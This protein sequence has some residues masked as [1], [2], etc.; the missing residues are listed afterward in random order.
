MKK[1]LVLL[2]AITSIAINQ[3]IAQSENN[4]L[5]APT[6][7]EEYNYLTK[8]YK[9]QVESG[10]D[11]KKGYSLIDMGTYQLSF[12]GENGNYVRTVKFKGLLR[13]G[14][15]NNCAILCI[16]ERKDTGF[17]KYICIPSNNASTKLWNKTSDEMDELAKDNFGWSQT[18]FWA[19][20]KLNAL[21]ASTPCK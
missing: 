5:P 21:Q 19:L 10:L 1:V 17:K 14:D 16:C 9:I 11:M 6:T 4:Q 2:V 13:D 7:E 18:L 8:G 3:A 12:K 15:A 20:S